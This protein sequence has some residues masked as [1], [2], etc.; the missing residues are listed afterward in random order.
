[1]NKNTLEK[2][3]NSLEEQL[4]DAIEIATIFQGLCLRLGGVMDPFYSSLIVKE[5]C[6]KLDEL[7]EMPSYIRSD[8][9]ARYASIGACSEPEIF[10]V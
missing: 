4:N 7:K 1:M 5:C 9:Y 8:F 6:K 2:R 10:T 3:I